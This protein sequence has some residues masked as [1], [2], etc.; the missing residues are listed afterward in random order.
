MHNGW[1]DYGCK[2]RKNHIKFSVDENSKNKRTKQIFL[3]F[4]DN[5]QIRKTHK[6]FTK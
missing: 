1:V 2:T 3:L 4:V 6:I 5:I